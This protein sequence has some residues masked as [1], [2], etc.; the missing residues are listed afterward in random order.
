MCWLASLASSNLRHRS[1]F[2]TCSV[3]LKPCPLRSSPL[4]TGPEALNPPNQSFK[5]DLQLYQ[6]CRWRRYWAIPT[7]KPTVIAIV[8]IHEIGLFAMGS[9]TFMP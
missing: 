9:L 8:K 5:T 2:K 3:G 4:L 6:K 7:M 1:V